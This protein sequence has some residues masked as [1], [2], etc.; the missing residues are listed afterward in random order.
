[1]WLNLV[2]LAGVIVGAC[3]MYIY[4]NGW[5]VFRVRVAE[6]FGRLTGRA[7]SGPIDGLT[8]P[9]DSDK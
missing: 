2:F 5:N 8:P 6:F 4:R 7:P 3:G 1:M 9:S